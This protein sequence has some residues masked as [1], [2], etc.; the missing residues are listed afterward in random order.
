MSLSETR[1]S[2]AHKVIG[3]SLFFTIVHHITGGC[4]KKQSARA[5]I[6]YIKVNFH[7][8]NFEIVDK[9]IDT[10][11]PVTDT[12]QEQRDEILRQKGLVFDFISYGYAH[13][14]RKG[15]LTQYELNDQRGKEHE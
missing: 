6:D 15:V 2:A 5:G 13:R 12:D 7:L 4:G 9:I 10:V 3:K 1:A 11:A 8:D 14:V